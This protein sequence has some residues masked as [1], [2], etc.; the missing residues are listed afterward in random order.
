[1]ALALLALVARAVVFAAALFTA[2]AVLGAAPVLIAPRA[3][4]LVLVG[5]LPLRA[6][7]IRFALGLA[8]VVRVAPVVVSCV[9]IALGRLLITLV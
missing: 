8:R 4:A 7:R 2:A 6:A 9:A 3:Q 1:M 5:Q